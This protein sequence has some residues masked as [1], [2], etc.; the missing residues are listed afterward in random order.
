MARAFA[1]ALVLR[2]VGGSAPKPLALS[3][4]ST[5]CCIQKT[6]LSPFHYLNHLITL[7]NALLSYA[8]TQYA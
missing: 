1:T 7:T 2:L 3:Q 6:F 4:Y 8:E 5:Q